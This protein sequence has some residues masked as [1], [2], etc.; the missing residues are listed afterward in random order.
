MNVKTEE[1]M[2]TMY[3]RDWVNLCDTLSD[4]CVRDV[5]KRQKCDR[6]V[7]CDI[8]R[9]NNVQMALVRWREQRKR[10][11]W[12]GV[13]QSGT[14]GERRL[15]GQS[16]CRP[17]PVWNLTR[18]RKEVRG[19]SRR[20]GG[21]DPGEGGDLCQGMARRSGVKGEDQGTGNP[22]G[23]PWEFHFICTPATV[24]SQVKS[25]TGMEGR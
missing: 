25:K 8:V 14:K 10:Q 19:G 5:L 2:G 11:S 16:T 6:R 20:E 9:C 23:V 1:Y 21:R 15:E 18:T 24:L 7:V 22:W 3:S 17:N 4:T 13:W 12:H